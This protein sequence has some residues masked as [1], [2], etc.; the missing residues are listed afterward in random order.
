M[1]MAKKMKSE[2]ITILVGTGVLFLTSGM[3][4]QEASAQL[5]PTVVE[6]ALPGV[7]RHQANVAQS[8]MMHD[9]EISQ[10]AR[11]ARIEKELKTAMAAQSMSARPPVVTTA[12]Q[13]LEANKPPPAPPS[14]TPRPEPRRGG[15]EV[16]K[17]DVPTNPVKP[18]GPPPE[19]AVSAEDAMNQATQGDVELP[20]Q[21]GGFFSK[22]FGKKKAGKMPDTPPEQPVMP[23][24]Y[25][26][27]PQVDSLPPETVPV[28]PETALAPTDSPEPPAGSFEIP[29]APAI[30]EAPVAPPKPA[31]IETIAS[32]FK[33]KKGP[34]AAGM[35]TVV[36]NVDANVSGV[37]VKLFKGDQVELLEQTGATARVRL[38]D[39][40]VGT[41]PASVLR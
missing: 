8:K 41:V 32:I 24:E 39:Q 23:A 5:P 37:L 12:A 19:P 3:H 25:P 26:D 18:F 16:P 17:F 7:Y 15:Q 36:S 13:F 20:E 22:L 31:P 4:A 2:R 30:N 10:A 28:S 35:S 27:A 38:R 33:K 11:S 21:K 1:A 40:R 6:E 9:R 34:A 29:D 14:D